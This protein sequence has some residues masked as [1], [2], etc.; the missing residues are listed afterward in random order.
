MTWDGLSFF[1]GTIPYNM[2]L[3]IFCIYFAY[4]GI[5]WV[6]CWILMGWF[7]LS[8]YI[9]I[10]IYRYITIVLVYG[11]LGILDIVKVIWKIDRR[12]K[13]MRHFNITV[14]MF[15]NYML[16]EVCISSIFLWKRI[17]K[18]NRSCSWTSVIPGLHNLNF[19]NGGSQWKIFVCHLYS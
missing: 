3:Q 2:L 7:W 4:I 12:Y 5:L 19:H 6:K 11:Q 1:R 13:N 8:T 17:K 10:Y 18:K 9:Y 16:I 14:F 15:L